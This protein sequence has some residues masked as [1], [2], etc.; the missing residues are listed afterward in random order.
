MGH[1]VEVFLGGARGVVEHDAVEVAHA[2]HHL[3]G[4]AEGAVPHDAEGGVQAERSPYKLSRRLGPYSSRFM[5]YWVRDMIGLTTVMVSTETIKGS[6][7]RYRESER[8]YSFHSCAKRVCWPAN[9]EWLST[10]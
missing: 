7:V 3:H 5:V 2:G 4:V 1:V 9:E 10:K 6:E 8:E